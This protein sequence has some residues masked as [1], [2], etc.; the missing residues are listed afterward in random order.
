MA[1][2]V[3]INDP[4]PVPAALGLVEPSARPPRLAVC[5]GPGRWE[6]YANAR[7]AAKREALRRLGDILD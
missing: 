1:P 4:D 3:G 5:S 6:I 7:S 2:G